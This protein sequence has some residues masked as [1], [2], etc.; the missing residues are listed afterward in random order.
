MTHVAEPPVAGG[1]QAA[2]L[3]R[4]S[5]WI[6]GATVAGTSGRTGP[7][8]NPATG[9]LAREVDFASTEEVGAAVRAARDDPDHPAIG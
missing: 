4:V 7:V 5:H 1:G 3:E 2:E 6:N 8:Y 9:E